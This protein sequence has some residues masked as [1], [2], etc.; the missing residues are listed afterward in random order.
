MSIAECAKTAS[1]RQRR[2]QQ[3]PTKFQSTWDLWNKYLKEVSLSPA[4]FDSIGDE[5][6]LAVG[7][8]F[9]EALRG[10]AKSGC[11]LKQSSI[12]GNI[13]ALNTACRVLGLYPPFKPVTPI[14]L[15]D[16][17]AKLYPA[18]H[19]TLQAFRKE[20][21]ASPQYVAV[22]KE[23]VEDIKANA[24][25]PE[26]DPAGA[27]I[28][29]VMELAF[30]FLLR[31]KEYSADSLLIRHIAF[32]GINRCRILDKEGFAS[33]GFKA[34]WIPAS[35]ASRTKMLMDAAHSVSLTLETQKNGTL[36]QVVSL[37]RSGPRA[38]G[39]PLCPV[40]GAARLVS[41]AF[42]LVRGL[43][44]PLLA[45]EVKG[46]ASSRV[47][48][49][50]ITTTI[51]TWARAHPQVYTPEQITRLSAHGLRGGGTQSYLNDGVSPIRVKAIGRWNSQ[52][53]FELYANAPGTQQAVV[54]TLTSVAK[55]RRLG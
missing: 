13:G 30:C 33:A 54:S 38:D 49:E 53:Q 40:S 42:S 20:D 17:A 48:A 28:A 18:V 32:Y 37:E 35:I 39:V 12:S 51:R 7:L 50:D 31:G 3:I 15:Q 5:R 14:S 46:K 4:Q 47:A 55:R 11:P 2:A 21:G 52:S 29:A 25:P 10:G 44:T 24:P 26:V 8:T 45:I 6:R 22:S 43:D 34:A 36:G 27:R 23:C 16:E 1:E 9:I 19:R 41:Q